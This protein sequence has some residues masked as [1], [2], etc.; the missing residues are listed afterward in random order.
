[1]L[2]GHEYGV[3]GALTLP[4]GRLLSWSGDKTLRL[5][6]AEGAPL[7]VLRGHQSEVKGARTLPDGRLLSWSDDN[8]LRLWSWAH[9]ISMRW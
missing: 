6:S 3:Y 5:W 4:D 7:T 2:R 1:V 8:T 9:C